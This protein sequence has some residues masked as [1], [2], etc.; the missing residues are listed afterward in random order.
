MLIYANLPISAGENGLV[1]K[2][3]EPTSGVMINSPGNSLQEISNGVFFVDVSQTINTDL[4]ADV[5]D[6]DGDALA[7]DWLYLGNS[8]VGLARTE[9]LESPVYTNVVRRNVNDTNPLFFEWP[10][11]AASLS[12]SV[13][14]NGG[15]YTTSTGVASFVRSESNSNLYALSY[16]ANDRPQTGVAEYKV[17]DGVNTRI[18]P[19]SIDS[20]GS[21]D[22]LLKTGVAY[23][24]T[25]NESNK[26]NN[27]TIVEPS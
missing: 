27:V 17:T 1:L 21:T 4:R 24:W 10:T 15:Y 22:G 25:N 20:G 14:I 7:S 6:A 8:V 9:E 18:I 13:S 19:L 16:D 5:F 26:F 3:Y 11:P 12:V 2:L 23:N